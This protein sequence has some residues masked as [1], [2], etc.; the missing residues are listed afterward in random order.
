MSRIPYSTASRY[1]FPNGK[2]SLRCKCGS[3]AF[4]KFGTYFRD[5]NRIQRLKCKV[6]DTVLSDT[7]LRPLG[8][9]RVPIEQ[10]ALVTGLLVEG[11]TVRG[12]SRLTG[13]GS[14]S[15]PLRISPPLLKQIEM[16]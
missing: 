9:L 15:L 4:Q 1:F 2:A 7:S 11:M 8:N 14:F 6:C 5:G 3:E 16:S 12:A 13:L 10:A